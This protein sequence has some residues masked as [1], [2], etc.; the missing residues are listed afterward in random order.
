MKR[1]RSCDSDTEPTSKLEDGIQQSWPAVVKH[2]GT[3]LSD[4]MSVAPGTPDIESAAPPVSM[5]DFIAALKPAGKSAAQIDP[6]ATGNGNPIPGGG[7]ILQSLAG[8]AALREALLEELPRRLNRSLNIEEITRLNGALDNLAGRAIL[9]VAAGQRQLVTLALQDQNKFLAL[10][11]H[12]LRGQLNA[13]LL[14]IEVLRS[15]LAGDERAAESL[16]DLDRMRRA[17]SEVFDKIDQLLRAREIRHGSGFAG[18]K[19]FR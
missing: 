10:A 2:V 19:N 7:D 14:T 1:Q 8:Y 5:E 9:G 16:R 11:N 6:Q 4:I 17:I 3:M 15:A 12:E 18:K 13:A